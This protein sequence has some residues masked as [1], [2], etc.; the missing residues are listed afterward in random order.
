MPNR[1]A[2]NAAHCA[3]PESENSLLSEGKQPSTPNKKA[4]STNGSSLLKVNRP[5]A[6]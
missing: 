6:Y 1:L 4:A 5:K 3:P 2:R